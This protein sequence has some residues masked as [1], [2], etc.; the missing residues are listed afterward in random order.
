MY[1]RNAAYVHLGMCVFDLDSQY[2][3]Q[4]ITLAMSRARLTKESSTCAH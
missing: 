2:D 4:H 1:Q 3:T